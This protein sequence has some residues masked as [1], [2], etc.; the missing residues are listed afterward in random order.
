MSEEIT[1]P[2]YPSETATI[3]T[4]LRHFGQLRDWV[5]DMRFWANETAQAHGLTEDVVPDPETIPEVPDTNRYLM[6]SIVDIVVA[7]SSMRQLREQWDA[8]VRE[9][10]EDW[11]A[12]TAIVTRLRCIRWAWQILS[13][14]F[15]LPEVREAMAEKKR[16]QIEAA[17]NAAMDKMG[18]PSQFRGKGSVIGMT[19]VG[20]MTHL[21]PDDPNAIDFDALFNGP[22]I[23]DGD[24]DNNPDEP[25]CPSSDDEPGA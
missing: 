22:P 13:T 24:Q 3:H 25:S 17:M 18:I 16:K 14:A 19:P 4:M 6:V 7:Y 8:M 5:V 11:N 10:E 9:S 2:P 20:P 21:E 1:S 23:P 12:K 15:I